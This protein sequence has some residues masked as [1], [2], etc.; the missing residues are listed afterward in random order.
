LF[1]ES[2]KCCGTD[3]REKDKVPPSTAEK[4]T[5]Q[6]PDTEEVDLH[7]ENLVE[8][9]GS[10]TPS[11]ILNIQMARFTTQPLRELFWPDKNGSFL[12]MV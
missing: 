12:F 2:G 4:K 1:I 5:P 7:I 8:N 9:P 3:F 6:F 11:E 10:L